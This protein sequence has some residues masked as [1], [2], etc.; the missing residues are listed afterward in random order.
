M[1]A[2]GLRRGR[3]EAGHER[4]RAPDA[5]EVVDANRSLD[6]VEVGLEERS[7]RRHAG[8]VDEHVD[9]RV[10]LEHSLRERLDGGPVGDVAHLDLA[11]DLVGELAEKVFAPRDED[12][13]PAAGGQR[14]GGR[15][16]DARRRSGDDGD[17]L[18]ARNLQS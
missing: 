2:A 8:V 7:P 9:R 6:Q 12:A 15:L 3:L 14:A 18:H 5:A 17:P 11:A 4:A 16:A 10:A 13:A 1:R